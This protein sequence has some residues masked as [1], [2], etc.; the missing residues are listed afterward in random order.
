MSRPPLPEPVD[1]SSRMGE[2]RTVTP[3]QTLWTDVSELE[4]SDPR[5]LSFVSAS[6]S[7]TA[8]HHPAWASLL[9][10]CTG[11]ARLQ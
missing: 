3:A 8:F 2:G 4:L 5:W 10:D 1:G 11:F 6:P 9:S 7:A